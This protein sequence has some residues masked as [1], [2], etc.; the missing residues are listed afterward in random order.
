MNCIKTKVNKY[1]CIVLRDHV[2]NVTIFIEKQ[3]G[4]HH[5]IVFRD[6]V[7][8]VSMLYSETK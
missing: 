6:K 8:D 5:F 7:I 1:Y 2:L 3:V 4:R